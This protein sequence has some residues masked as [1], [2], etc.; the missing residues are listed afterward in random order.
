MPC[1][2][3]FGRGVCTGCEPTDFGGRRRTSPQL[4]TAGL[5]RSGDSGL[6]ACSMREMLATIFVNA[7]SDD[8]AVAWGGTPTFG[9]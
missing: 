3:L 7:F 6:E 1:Q 5:R 2:D 8:P 4:E 9:R